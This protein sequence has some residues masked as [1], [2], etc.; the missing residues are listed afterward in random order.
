MNAEPTDKAP[1]VDKSDLDEYVAKVLETAPPLTPSQLD[2]IGNLLR[3]GN[4]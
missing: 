4:K 3:G 2:K 1:E